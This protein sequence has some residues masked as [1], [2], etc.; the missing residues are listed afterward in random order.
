MAKNGLLNRLQQ[1]LL[2]LE[3]GEPVDTTRQLAE[4][5]ARA[6][7]TR[8]PGQDPATRTFQALRIH[9]NQELE[10][11]SLALPAERA[12]CCAPAGGSSSSASIPW[13]IASSSGSCAMNRGPRPMPRG[14]P[15]RASEMPPPR[16]RLIGKPQRPARRRDRRQSARAQR[17]HASRGKVTVPAPVKPPHPVG[18]SAVMLRL[19]LVLLHPGRALRAGAGHFAAPGAQAVRAAAKE[20]EAT[21]QLEVEWGQLQLEQS[22]WAMHARIEKIASGNLQH[23]RA[24]PRQLR[25]AAAVRRPSAGTQ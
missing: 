24:R 22:T 8:E 11:L 17:G 20:Q 13:R 25:V 23:A 14:L 2:R 21:K 10:E 4:I 19:N 6:V 1:R 7:R 5:V 18:E 3:R 15:V 9:V 12:N 16:L